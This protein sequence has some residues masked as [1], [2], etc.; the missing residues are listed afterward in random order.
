MRTHTG[1]KP[2]A[3]KYCDTKFSDFGSRNKHERRHTGERPYICATCGKT[4][5]YSYVLVNH[6]MTHTGEKKYECT[7]CSKRFTK[8]HHLKQH[9]N[10]HLREQG[11]P[12]T[13]YVRKKKAIAED[14]SAYIV[15]TVQSVVTLMS[16]EI[17]EIQEVH[18]D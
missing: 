11:L 5:T 15:N 4:F 10:V 2:Y 9:N 12:Y 6:M 16:D 18:D 1:E 13:K 3:C 14:S 17:Q 7:V 8:S